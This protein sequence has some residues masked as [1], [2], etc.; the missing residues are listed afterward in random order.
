LKEALKLVDINVLD[1]FVV[2]GRKVLS[3]AE[4]GLL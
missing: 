4:H 2:G 3:F 1:H